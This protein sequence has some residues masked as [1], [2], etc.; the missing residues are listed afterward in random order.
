MQ[1]FVHL[2][3]HTEYSL[4]DGACR[5]DELMDAVAKKGQTAVAM[6]D[7]G[8]MYGAITFYKAAKKK[9]IKPIIGCEVYVSPRSRFD[10]DKNFDTEYKHLVLLCE[11]NEGYDNLIKLV[12]AGF[13]EGFYTKPRI[14][15]ELLKRHSKGLI[16]LSACLAG[17][18]PKLLAAGKYEDAKN[19]ALEMREIFGE[20]NFYL[21]LQDHGI[22]E[23][24]RVK[25]GLLKIANETGIPTVCTNDVHYIEKEDSTLQ[26]VLICIQTNTTIKEKSP[27]AFPTNEFYLKTAE[28][29]AALFP[30]E[31]LQNSVKIA[32]RCNVEFEFGKIKLPVFDIGERDH[33]EYFKEKCYEG[34]YK[35]FGKN[36]PK[37]AMDRLEYELSVIFQMGY[38][39]YYLIVQ[40][41][42]NYAK[43]KGI[44]VGPGR[45]SG[46][47]SLAAFCI[48]ITGID[49]IKYNLLFERFLNPE[50]I[51]MPDFDIDF[52]YIRRQEVIDYVTE[53][54]GAD[55]V[56][57]IVTFGT[58][59]ARGAIRDVGRALAIP[60]SVCD[61]IAKLVPNSLNMTIDKALSE[62][63]DLKFA[64]EENIEV[65]EL[66]NNARRVEG[67]PR[68]ASTH[69]AGVVI[70]DKPISEY[71]P[72]ATND[73]VVVTQYT[74]TLLEELGL[75]KMDFLGLRNLTVIDDTV[76]MLKSRGIELDIENIPIDD[77]ETFSMMSKGLTEGVFQFE[78]GGM[79]SVLQSFGPEKIEDLIAILSLYR[80]G[81]MDSI[82]KYIYNH[83]HPD[84]IKYDTP[85]LKP[86][87][88]ETYG[89]IVY[90]EQV[91]QVF[92]TLAGYSLGRADIVRRA[93]SK[94]KHDVLLREKNAFIFGEEGANGCIG[95]V[96]NGVPQK[97]AEKIF[98]DIEAFSSYA[99]NKSHAAAY[100][101]VAYRTAYLKCHYPTEYLA[102]LLTSVLDST[103]KVTEYIS[104]CSRMG[105]KILPP[106]INL[107]EAGFTAEGNEIRFGLLGIKNLGAGVIDAIV[108]ERKNGNYKSLEDLCDRLYGCQLNR[109]A[110]ENLVG[111]GA[112]D[113]LGAW[114]SQMLQAID[115]VLKEVDT[116]K[117]REAIGQLDIFA[118]AGEAP[119]KEEFQMPKIEEIPLYD[120]LEYEKEA[121][122][123][124]ISGHPM[125]EYE[126]YAERQKSVRSCELADT[127]NATELDDKL[128][129]VVGIVEE[130]KKR[131]QKNGAMYG[132]LTLEDRFGEFRIL[133]FANKLNQYEQLCQ[134]GNILNIRG[135]VSVNSRGESGAEI[136]CDKMTVVTP[137]ETKESSKSEKKAEVDKTQMSNKGL[138]LR[139]P[140]KDSDAFESA[141]AICECHEGDYNVIIYCED[142]G[143]RMVA[144]NQRVAYNEELIDTLYIIL[145][146]KNVKFIT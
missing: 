51:S 105:I 78:S 83:K 42:V 135:R 72:V 80:P 20:N 23:E 45:G 110:L 43:S 125:Q 103:A 130:L 94:K 61:K 73:G 53:K 128:V 16:A 81:P 120:R 41:F 87:L 50:R 69:A 19:S 33:F 97:I 106:S 75:L 115:L 100:S 17:E 11:N 145:G 114:R 86:I 138:W 90:Q 64:Y 38:V 18:I 71:V 95:C 141:L 44:P 37:E 62:V 26:K 58:M 30:L 101:I 9:G 47:G 88:E 84:K 109:K 140:S 34:L 1:D 5:I 2:H 7:H 35:H 123:V 4:L 10:K 24:L 122:G 85:L 134:K 82:P 40:D 121:L 76:K 60:Y 74:M 113:G 36:P 49:S 31:S 89:C 28:E 70:S 142:S 116:R 131:A 111:C 77:K 117:K 136:I 65:R 146:E 129:T 63:A 102:A 93:M 104:E 67:M 119:K 55:H 25:A 54:Y 48:G 27:L 8:V 12:S 124:Y 66:I 46:A 91:M 139:V 32:E 137:E 6:T 14:D 98:D 127:D 107:S 79:K 144:N 68:H 13:T 108:G 118:M 39:D 3:L 112:L 92:R 133:V 57:Q 29:M 56:A 22:E 52:C 126:D 21:E 59:A 132:V 96:K 99:F 15:K 143:K